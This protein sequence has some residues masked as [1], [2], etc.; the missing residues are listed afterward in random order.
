M[1]ETNVAGLQDDSIVCRENEE[2]C[3]TRKT[4]PVILCGLCAELAVFSSHSAHRNKGDCAVDRFKTFTKYLTHHRNEGM[5]HSSEVT[6][7]HKQEAIDV[8]ESLQEIGNIFDI[9]CVTS[10][11][12][13]HSW[14][15]YN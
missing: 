4:N 7:L 13:I 12:M 3:H 14:R 1:L 11:W 8:V 9:L 10:F 6:I 15:V 5:G 2:E